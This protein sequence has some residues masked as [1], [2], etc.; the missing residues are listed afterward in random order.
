MKNLLR[1][2]KRRSGECWSD[3]SIHVLQPPASG[4]SGVDRAGDRCLSDP[5]ILSTVDYKG[6][7]FFLGLSSVSSCCLERDTS[8]PIWV[9]A[10]FQ[11]GREGELKMIRQLIKWPL[12]AGQCGD[13]KWGLPGGILRATQPCSDHLLPAHQGISRG[14]GGASGQP[15]GTSGEELSART[16]APD[17]VALLPC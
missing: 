16:Q 1:V 17:S 15:Q 4:P 8:S 3:S 5:R 14:Q 10:D 13:P 6:H 11:T 2:N 9:S 7:F 12:F